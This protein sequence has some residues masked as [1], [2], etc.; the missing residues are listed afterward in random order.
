MS[1]GADDSFSLW[2]DYLVSGILIIKG[3]EHLRFKLFAVADRLIELYSFPFHVWFRNY[4]KISMI[5]I[6]N[7][8]EVSEDFLLS[9]L[10]LPL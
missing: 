1:E 2:I 8:R 10:P 6:D 5:S 4:K 7:L 9:V 3:D